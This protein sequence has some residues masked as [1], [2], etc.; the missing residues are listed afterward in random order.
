M[1]SFDIIR[2]FYETHI[3][4]LIEKQ[5]NSI[6]FDNIEKFKINLKISL[7][8]FNNIKKLKSSFRYYIIIKA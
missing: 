5:N 7:Y 1:P 3:N 6:E 8:Y 2:K 4:P